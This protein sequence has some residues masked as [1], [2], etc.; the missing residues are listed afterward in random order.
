MLGVSD[1]KAVANYDTALHVL[2]WLQVL[3]CTA[4]VLLTLVG[5]AAQFHP[6][7]LHPLHF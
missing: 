3:N 4:G 6:D 2:H 1:A 5:F 7:S